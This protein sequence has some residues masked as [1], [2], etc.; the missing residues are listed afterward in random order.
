MPKRSTI[1][2]DFTVEKTFKA[3]VSRVYQMFADKPSKERWFRA[4]GDVK[5]DHTMD[6]RVG[7]S[8]FNSGQFSDGQVHTFKAYYYDIVPN[9]RIVYSYDM[10]LDD[11]RISVSLTTLEFSQEDQTTKLVLHEAGVFLYGYDQP[12]NREQGSQE[13]LKALELAIKN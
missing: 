8:E 10:Y 7:G 11:K 5:V 2:A 13:L 6:F 12:S 9:E 3:P 4:P 1:Y